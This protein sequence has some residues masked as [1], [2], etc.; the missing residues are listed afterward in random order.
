VT[1]CKV[2]H[3]P[4]TYRNLVVV[5]PLRWNHSWA[6]VEVAVAEFAGRYKRDDRD[7]DAMARYWT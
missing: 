7:W 5:I 3:H 1:V 6:G 4:S 2:E